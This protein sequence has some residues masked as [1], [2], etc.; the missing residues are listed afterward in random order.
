MGGNLTVLNLL[1]NAVVP[2]T[3]TAPNP[4]SISD[5]PRRRSRMLL[6]DDNTLWIG[7]TKCIDGVRANN[8]SASQR[9]R[10]PDHGEH[11]QRTR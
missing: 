8:P 11:H 9:K 6:A 4:V 7:M 10:L 3:A 5:G 2:E 1:S